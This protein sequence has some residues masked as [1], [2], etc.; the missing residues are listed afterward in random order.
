[1]IDDELDDDVA[2]E[3]Y[4]VGPDEFMAKRAE[5]AARLKQD[6]AA[7]AAA[8]VAKLRK[9][10]VAAWIVNAFVLEHP[11]ELDRIADI[12]DRLRAAQHKLEAPLLRELSQERRALVGDADQAGPRAGRSGPPRRARCGTRSRHVRRRGRRPR[13]RGA[14]GP[15]AAPGAVLRLRLRRRRPAAADRSCAAAGTARPAATGKPAQRR[16]SPSATGPE[17]PRRRARAGRRP[18]S[19]FEQAEAAVDDAQQRRARRR[20]AAQDGRAGPG[21]GARTR[22]RHARHE[23]DEARENLRTAKDRRREARARSTGPS[24]RPRTTT[25]RRLSGA[26]RRGAPSGRRAG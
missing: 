20:P 6:G 12:G 10:T 19:A 1:M 26:R 18:G 25:D 7:G 8:A 4:A 21:Q 24:A 15:A 2:R 16:R 17:R 5:V 13:D 9:P 22:S 14:V 3:L 11:D 23:L